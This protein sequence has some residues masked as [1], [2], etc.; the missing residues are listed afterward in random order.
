VLDFIVVGFPR[1][2]TSWI[3]NW[4]T[5][6]DTICLHDPLNFLYPRQIERL[7]YTGKRVGICCTGSWLLPEWVNKQGVRTAV[8]TRDRDCRAASLSRFGFHPLPEELE[9]RASKINGLRFDFDDL[10]YQRE[11]KALW[12]YL[13]PG[14]PFDLL[15]YNML[16]DLNIQP[17]SSFSTFDPAIAEAVWSEIEE[18]L[19]G[20]ESEEVQSVLQSLRSTIKQFP[21]KEQDCYL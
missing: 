18:E 8:I 9:T 5:T 3:S 15:R 2:G 7:E 14:K 21:A 20:T 1:S 12:E 10:W 19:D 11:A 6:D 16:R 4:L 13:M 17:R